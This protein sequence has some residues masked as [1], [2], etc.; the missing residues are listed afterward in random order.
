MFPVIY[1]CCDELT[2]DL[3]VER[4]VQVEWSD[5]RPIV[6]DLVSMGKSERWQVVEVACF[7]PAD[8]SQDVKA[9]FLVQV[10]I[11]GLVIPPREQWMC[12]LFKDAHPDE[13]IH[14]NLVD[15]AIEIG[16]NMDGQSPDIG[17][18]LL[19]YEQICE[20]TAMRSIERP[21]IV[22]RIALYLPNGT[23]PYSKVHLCHCKAL[24]LI[25]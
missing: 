20:T 4:S 12:N 1:E 2:I 14:L 5:R 8:L 11:Q 23:A 16:F 18:H 3:P 10:H 6:G 22:D 24:S 21:W 13:S 25:A 17:S 19:N 15:D 9:V 7:E